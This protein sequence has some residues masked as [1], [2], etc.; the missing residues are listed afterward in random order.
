MLFSILISLFWLLFYPLLQTY[1]VFGGDGGDLIS[2]AFLRGVPHPPG[3]PLYTFIAYLLTKLPLYT[4]AWRVALLSSIPSALTLVILF[5]IFKQFFKNKWLVAV[6]LLTVG[7]TYPFWEFAITVEV[8]A[9]NTLFSVLLIYLL[10]LWSN[11]KKNKY[12]YIFLFLAGVAFSHHQLILFLFPGFVYWIYLNRKLLPQNKLKLFISAPVLFILGL[13]PYLYAYLA[14]KSFPW[15]MWSNP[16]NFSNLV[17]LFLKESYGI[18]YSGGEFTKTIQARLLEFPAYF[19]FLLEDFTI[20]GILVITTGL[21]Y[22][23]FKRQKTA[24]FFFLLWLF[25]GPLLYFYAG[26]YIMHSFRVAIYEQFLGF[27]YIFIAF[28]LCQGLIVIKNL[29]Q[30]FFNKILSQPKY[31]SEPLI[32]VFLFIYP[33]TIFY[34]NYPKLAILKNDFTAENLGRDIL[35]TT[36][37]KGIL[38]L[39]RDTS[40]FDSQYVYYIEGN[41][42]DLKIFHL[43]R[44]LMD[45][46]KPLITKYYPELN[47]TKEDGKDTFQSFIDNNYAKFPIYSVIPYG[48]FK[49][50]C[51]WVNYGMLFR[52]Y[53]PEDVPPP[54]EIIEKNK[55]IFQSYHDPLAGSLSKYQNLYPANILSFYEEAQRRF[56]DMLMKA[57]LFTEALKY[58][59]QA[60]RLAPDNAVNYS[61]E[62]FAYFYLKKCE[63]A[64]TAVKKAIALDKNEP[65]YYFFMAKTY[66]ECFKDENKARENY[67]IFEQMTKKSQT[68]LEKL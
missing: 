35:N 43:E 4:V 63:E 65:Q 32:I 48:C 30:S 37:N 12:L 53:K 56:G 10:L 38:F 57:D 28:F 54:N 22:Q 45:E 5:L 23:L 58:Y 55:K 33:L 47:L 8:Y 25:S 13:F 31:V 6:S 16:Y 51:T 61:N 52:V 44:F 46:Y 24:V 49:N 60:E 15:L 20:V 21:I 29:L 64:I 41:R 50:E 1:S 40:L 68:P 67:D 14:A 27:S 2:A 3:F 18:V 36:G 26:F 9:L 11:S 42:A 62:A 66:Q 59:K 7:F 34:I 39:S 19:I 17:K